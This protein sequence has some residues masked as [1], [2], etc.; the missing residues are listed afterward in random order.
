MPPSL[1]DAPRPAH[2]YRVRG[3]GQPHDRNTGAR[4]ALI[5]SG[6]RVRY[7]PVLTGTDRLLRGCPSPDAVPDRPSPECGGYAGH[8]RPSRPGDVHRVEGTPAPARGSRTSSSATSSPVLPTRGGAVRCP[9]A[10]RGA[11]NTEVVGRG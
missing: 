2:A 6:E 3:A 7:M 8:A 11:G 5:A 9:R 4:L 10:R 1:S